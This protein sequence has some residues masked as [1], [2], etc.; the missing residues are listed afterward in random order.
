MLK[1]QRRCCELSFC[2]IWGVL[3]R[4]CSING[5]IHLLILRWNDLLT[6]EME[7]TFAFMRLLGVWLKGLLCCPLEKTNNLM[8]TFHS[9]HH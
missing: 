6:V 8:V 2:D 7:L 1:I 4:I 9:C 3:Q 5:Q